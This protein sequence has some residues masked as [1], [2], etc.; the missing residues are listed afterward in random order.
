MTD[1]PNHND[2]NL[3]IPLIAE[4]N[5]DLSLK[6]KEL[7]KNIVKMME[8]VSAK[9]KPH[10]ERKDVE[11]YK[12]LFCPKTIPDNKKLQVHIRVK[13]NVKTDCL[14]C[15]MKNESIGVLQ[16]HVCTEHPKRDDVHKDIKKTVKEI[17]NKSIN[18]KKINEMKKGINITPQNSDQDN[19][20]QD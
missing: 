18:K 10:A 4:Q 20:S 19:K 5:V 2:A 14:N 6:L 13:H 15:G 16:E 9:K 12:C 3:F 17:E 8:G 1:F 7:N 11:H